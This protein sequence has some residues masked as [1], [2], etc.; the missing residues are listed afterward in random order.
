MN[1]SPGE[2]PTP[3]ADVIMT[4]AAGPAGAA[5]VPV[6]EPM[7]HPAP[8]AP[9]AQPDCGCGQPN[10]PTCGSRTREA[11]TAVAGGY[12][13]ALGRIEA[14]FPNLSVEKEFAQATARAA[15][16]GLSD[17]EMLQTVLTKPENAY[18]ARQLCWILTIGGVD[19]YLLMPRDAADVD[20]LVETLR[21][22][23]G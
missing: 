15:T 13:Y 19:S 6:P 17:R 22:T 8:P 4:R 9:S 21:P 16:A 11:G 14:R 20:A 7:P 12:V 1:G 23:P 3:A 2:H 5:T 10:C 18:L